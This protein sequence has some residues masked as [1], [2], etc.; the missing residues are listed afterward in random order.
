[1]QSDTQNVRL[2]NEIS[3]FS[4]LW[5]AKVLQSHFS[6]FEC[7]HCKLLLQS[8]TGESYLIHFIVLYI[9]IQ[10]FQAFL[11]HRNV[12]EFTSST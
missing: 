8:K 12:K 9:K 4:Q 5:E 10:E 11:M 7:A 3:V 1:M 6:P 2:F